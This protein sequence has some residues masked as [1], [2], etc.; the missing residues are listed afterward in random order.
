MEAV[1]PNLRC[2][3]E[4]TKKKKEKKENSSLPDLIVFIAFVVII[5]IKLCVRCLHEWTSHKL[6]FNASHSL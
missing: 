2:D 6:F 1:K 3:D 5:S 4:F